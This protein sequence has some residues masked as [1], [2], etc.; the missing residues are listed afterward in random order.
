MGMSLEDLAQGV[1]AGERPALARA[2]SLAERDASAAAALM[3]K[4]AGER[5]HAHIIGI[6]GPPGAG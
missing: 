6:T 5:G 1:V 2:L 3:A 4:L